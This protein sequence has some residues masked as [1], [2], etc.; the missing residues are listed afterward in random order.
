MSLIA[1]LFFR[2]LPTN[3]M[4]HFSR[5]E[6]SSE[7]FE[8]FNWKSCTK[9]RP[10]IERWNKS[11]NFGLEPLAQQVPESVQDLFTF[12]KQPSPSEQNAIRR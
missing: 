12:T 11:K 10:E 8:K 4:E 6:D 3:A 1:Q 2:D 9:T 5:H 7:Q